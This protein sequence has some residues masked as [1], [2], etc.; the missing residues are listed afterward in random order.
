MSFEEVIYRIGRR[1]FATYRGARE[2]RTEPYI[3]YGEG[4]LE[5]ATKRRGKKTS[6]KT[7]N[8]RDKH[9]ARIFWLQRIDYARFFLAAFFFLAAIG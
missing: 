2:A 1:I 5:E 3:W 8:P 7:K 4:A 6:P 9:N